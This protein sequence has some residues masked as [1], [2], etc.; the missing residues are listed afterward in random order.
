[1]ATNTTE[2]SNKP[3]KHSGL[4]IASFVIALVWLFEII[5]F[6]FYGAIAGQIDNLGLAMVFIIFSAMAPIVAVML[7]IISLFLKN[8]K[9]LY[10]ILG[11]AIIL[12]F[13]LLYFF[14]FGSA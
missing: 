7:G 10:G 5:L 13:G 3:L 11:L 2:T 4:G 6:I 14:I 9:R 8:K 1:M 12:P